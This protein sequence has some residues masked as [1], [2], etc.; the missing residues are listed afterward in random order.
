MRFLFTIS[1]TLALATQTTV[2]FVSGPPQAVASAPAP[3]SQ[4]ID[5]STKLQATATATATATLT[6]DELKHKFATLQPAFT[7]ET[8]P[9]LAGG[10]YNIEQNLGNPKEDLVKLI[11]KGLSG[12]NDDD[13]SDQKVEF[14][15]NSETV[16]ALVYALYAEGKGFD[17]D[18]V[19]GDW[20]LVFSKQGKKSPKFQK[21]VGKKE[22]AGKTDNTFDIVAMTF[23]GDATILKKGT[24]GS[25]V[26]YNPVGDGFS[27]AVDGKV[28]LRRI[29]CDIVGAS[30]KFWFFPTIPLPLR[31]QGGSLDFDYMDN[32]IRVTRGNRGGLFVHF[33]PAFLESQLLK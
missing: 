17:A 6:A 30:W 8:S 29:M 18:V 32:D 16:E 11:V 21:L 28:V 23:S 33:R 15:T 4:V 19:E 26:K 10:W 5:A 24:I 1:A 22:K 13:N 9:V 2:A 20:K 31:V 12:N 27:K 25:T 7:T 3:T 14:E